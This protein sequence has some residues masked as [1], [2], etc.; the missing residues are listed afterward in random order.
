MLEIAML[1]GG[2]GSSVEKE[3]LEESKLNK[4]IN[5]WGDITMDIFVLLPH[6]QGSF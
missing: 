1:V 3:L 5:N 6:P 4:K 2:P